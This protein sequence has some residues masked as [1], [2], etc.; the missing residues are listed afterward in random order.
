VLRA[1]STTHDLLR[2]PEATLE[3]RI[4]KRPAQGGPGRRAEGHDTSVDQIVTRLLADWLES[5]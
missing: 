2:G 1:K 5:L 4:P 3:V